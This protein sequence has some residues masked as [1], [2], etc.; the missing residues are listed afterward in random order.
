MGRMIF[1]LS[2]SFGSIAGGYVAQRLAKVRIADFEKKAS[3]ISRKL[4]LSAFFFLN[5]VAL[6]STF[7]GMD[8]PDLRVLG[9]PI[10]GLVSVLIGMAAALATIRIL[11]I[12]PQQ[13]GSVFTCGTFSNILTM[14]GLIAYTFFREPG[15]ALVQLF[16]MAM[17]PAYYLLGYPISANI[18][19]GRKPTFKVS[20]ASFRENP[21]LVLPLAAVAVGIIIR[22]TGLPRPP[23]LG[24]VVAV[25]VPFVAGTLGL[26]IGLT[27]RFTRFGEYLREITAIVLIRHLLLPALMIPMGALLGFGSVSNGLPLKIIAIVSAMPVAFNALVPPAIYGFDLDLANSAWIA[28]TGLLAVIVPVLFLVFRFVS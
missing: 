27:L 21:F 6:L 28:S 18:G 9:L 26:A 11:R 4:K 14:G 15:Y 20:G 1:I 5:P 19:H 3:S 2:I 16:T 13:A 12:P 8:I 7:W 24:A 22:S 25:I 23:V 17:S 10:L